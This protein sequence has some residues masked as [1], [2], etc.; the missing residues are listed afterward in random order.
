MENTKKI[1]NEEK[2]IK[3]N[4]KLFEQGDK[5]TASV[6]ILLDGQLLKEP[7]LKNKTIILGANEFIPGFDQLLLD[8]KPEDYGAKFVLKF[9]APK[10]YIIE[11]FRNKAVSFDINIHKHEKSDEILLKKENEA[12]Q[13][14]IKKLKSEIENNKIIANKHKDEINKLN[15]QFQNKIKESAAKLDAELK[16]EKL[17]LS[18]LQDE[19]KKEAKMYALQKFMEDFLS[20]YANL[21]MAIN[22]AKKNE[23]P[24]VKNFVIGFEMIL[25][26][27]ENVFLDWNIN[28]IEPSIGEEFN[29]EKH[30]ILE[31]VIDLEMKEHTIKKVHSIGFTLHDRLIKPALVVAVLNGELKKPT[32]NEN[33]VEEKPEEQLQNEKVE[34]TKQN[35]EE[36][37]EESSKQED[38]NIKTEE[39]R[40]SWWAK[41]KK[42]KAE[43]KLKKM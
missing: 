4:L 25:K 3:N 26:Q 28:I 16:E 39:E 9:D 21:K 10:N 12:L 18:K 19:N 11:G 1:K 7:C 42:A 6:S 22:G 36:E 40:L 8:I 29:P 43:K 20:P 14:E 13:E 33:K 34:D 31:Q 24:A 17:R 32:I 15:L 30:Q 37:N 35:T 5:I 2:E 27:I 41:R 38:L 23:N